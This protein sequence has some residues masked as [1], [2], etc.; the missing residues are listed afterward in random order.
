MLRSKPS[1]APRN[2]QPRLLA[3]C[4][5][6]PLLGLHSATPC[7]NSRLLL[8]AFLPRFLGL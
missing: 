3:R 6:D 4:Y 8:F 1:G 7:F 5:D 2:C